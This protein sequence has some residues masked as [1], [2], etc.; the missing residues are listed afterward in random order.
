MTHPLVNAALEAKLHD[1]FVGQYL[2]GK[3][4]LR[5]HEADLKQEAVIGIMRAA[6][7][8]EPSRGIAFETFAW[9]MIKAAIRDY[10]RSAF[11]GDAP[12]LG[13][14]ADLA[15]ANLR[16]PCE[17]ESAETRLD[18]PKVWAQ[19]F[20]RLAQLPKRGGVHTTPNAV[21]ERREAAD[22]FM[23]HVVKGET[24]RK[25]GEDT[26]RTF[27]NVAKKVERMQVDFKR[28]FPA[29]HKALCS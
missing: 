22:V 4:M 2:R 11:G 14:N 27:Q 8:Y 25:I 20:E 9:W 3:P 19:T 15:I 18:A 7:I 29:A 17:I 16:A 10:L 21:R 26:G 23:R 24:L 12:T 13:A 1:R 28:L 6:E 5:N